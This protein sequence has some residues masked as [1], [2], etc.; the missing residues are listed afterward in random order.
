[1]TLLYTPA[2][3]EVFVWR[4]LSESDLADDSRSH[5]GKDPQHSP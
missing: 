2:Y 1:M 3:D 4:S 5:S